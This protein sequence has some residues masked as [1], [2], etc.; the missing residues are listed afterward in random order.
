MSRIGK[1]P[2]IIP[3]GVKVD[4]S[5][6]EVRITGPKG[7]L[8]CNL[9]RKTLVVLSGNKLLVSR[10]R[11]DKKV[12]SNHGT[13]RSLL[14]NM[15]LGVTE[16][17]KKELEIIGTGF[18]ID[19]EAGNLK[20]KIGFSHLVVVKPPEGITFEVE[21]NKVRVLGTDKEM[22]GNVAAKIRKIKPPD[23]YKGK[24]MRYLGETVKLKPGKAAKTGGTE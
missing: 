19:L 4:L 16:G 13:M 3:E 18:R 12:K 21:E 8:S 5:E 17:W 22:V 20:I 6:K 15:V 1:Q 24:G 23:V 11:D 9:L 14:R 10:E 2:I 7:T